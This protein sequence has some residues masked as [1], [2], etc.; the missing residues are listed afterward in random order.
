M[1]RCDAPERVQSSSRNCE[2]ARG[3][4]TN[5]KYVHGQEP[6]VPREE[7]ESVSPSSPFGKYDTT[8]EAALRP[9][10][11]Y[12]NGSAN[13]AWSPSCLT[14]FVQS[15]RKKSIRLFFSLPKE[16]TAGWRMAASKGLS[17][18]EERESERE[19]VGESSVL[20][21]ISGGASAR[22]C[23]AT[24]KI[25]RNIDGEKGGRNDFYPL[26]SSPSFLRP[27]RHVPRDANG[28][29]Q[30]PNANGCM[31]ELIF[32]RQE[33]RVFL[34]R[35]RSLVHLRKQS[36][37]EKSGPLTRTQ[38]KS[39]R[40]SARGVIS[41]QRISVERCLYS[42]PPSPDFLSLKFHEGFP[43]YRNV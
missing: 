33:T 41:N 43:R 22:A 12:G 13:G 31:M 17:R 1:E 5:G 38:I 34:D 42:L 29:Q 32:R 9:L 3:K 23:F 26:P 11:I 36:I 20:S 18:G 35:E 39:R 6:S 7:E 25:V 14:I 15:K 21:F 2:T 30:L 10:A 27:F 8:L 4:Y 19:G 16:T 40:V 37:A 24:W 28:N